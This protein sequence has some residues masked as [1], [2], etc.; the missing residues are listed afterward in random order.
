MRRSRVETAIHIV[1]KGNPEETE[2][3][4]QKIYDMLVVPQKQEVPVAEEKTET[5]EVHETIF[6]ETPESVAY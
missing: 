3:Q 5:L 1:L 4:I 2:S 6:E